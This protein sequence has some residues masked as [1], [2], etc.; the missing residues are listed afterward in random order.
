MCSLRQR[1]LLGRVVARLERHDLQPRATGH[2]PQSQ[3]SGHPDTHA[4]RDDQ[5]ECDGDAERQ[6]NDERIRTRGPHQRP[7]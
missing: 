4:D 3:H 5:I 2:R 6:G 7:D 1:V